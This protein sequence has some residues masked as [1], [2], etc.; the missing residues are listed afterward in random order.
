MEREWNGYLSWRS[1][2]CGRFVDE[3]VCEDTVE[4]G[5]LLALLV[6]IEEEVVDFV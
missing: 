4:D 5:K 1:G 6:E 2:V 3:S